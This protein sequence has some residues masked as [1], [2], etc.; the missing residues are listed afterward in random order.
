MRPIIIG[1]SPAYTMY[2][3]GTNSKDQWTTG[4]A[5]SNDGIHWTRTGSASIPAGSS[6][7]D[8]Y[9]H[10]ATSV[11]SIH[12]QYLMTY[13]G[14]AT[15]NGPWQIAFATST[16]GVN[17]NPYLQNPVVTYGAGPWDAGGVNYPMAVIVGDQYYVYYHAYSALDYQ[18]IALVKIPM[19]QIPAL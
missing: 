2:Y 16:D 12:G 7:W 14:H 1:N 3:Q 8:A 5:T 19:S 18:A 15:K 17:W 9:S 6:G 11:M 4:M 13:M 10:S